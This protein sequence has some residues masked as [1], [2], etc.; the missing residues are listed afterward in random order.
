[1]SK[2]DGKPLKRVKLKPERQRLKPKSE[3]QSPARVQLKTREYVRPEGPYSINGTFVKKLKQIDEGQQYFYDADLP[4]FGLRVGK[5]AK[6]YFAEHLIRGS[7]GKKRRVTI[8]RHGVVT[9]DQARR[10]A[11]R[12]ILRMSDGDDPR[13]EQLR[14]VEAA[15]KAK[16]EQITL[17]KLCKNFCSDRKGRLRKNTLKE[18]RRFINR[19]FEDWLDKPIASITGDDVWDKHRKIGLGDKGTSQKQPYANSALRVLSSMLGFAVKRRW[20][21][22]NPVHILRGE[23]FPIQRRKTFIKRDQLS[24]WFKGLEDVRNDG[25]LPSSDV[26]CDYLE[27]LLFTG[28]RRNEAAELTLKRTDLGRKEI[29]IKKT[30]NRK[31]HVLPMPDH[32]MKLLRRRYEKSKDMGSKWIF[33][34]ARSVGGKTHFSEPRDVALLIKAKSGIGF[35]PHDLRR[36]F[37]THAADLVSYPNLKALLNHSFNSNGDVTLGYVITTSEKL[38]EPMKIIAKFFLKK[39]AIGLRKKIK[40]SE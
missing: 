6:S 33:P 2:A 19:D 11:R 14:Q 9:A 37:A 28:L 23:W 21:E 17:E 38:K 26:G 3:K 34:S 29:T 1:M 36:T 16:A 15:Q 32:L 5:N 13:E 27:F 30:K 18:Y 8:G 35:T 25:V 10:R 4:G 12:L 31:E 39:R 40:G 7:G 20:L 22:S 24:G